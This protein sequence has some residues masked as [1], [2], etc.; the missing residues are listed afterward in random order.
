MINGMWSEDPGALGPYPSQAITL[1]RVPNGTTCII[2]LERNILLLAMAS[3]PNHKVRQHRSCRKILLSEFRVSLETRIKTLFL[4][5][6]FHYHMLYVFI[7]NSFI[8]S[9]RFIECLQSL[10]VYCNNTMIVVSL[11][12]VPVE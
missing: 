10:C 3:T 9:E 8:H 12:P 6:V 11:S 2:E 5:I 4:V 1:V 7:H